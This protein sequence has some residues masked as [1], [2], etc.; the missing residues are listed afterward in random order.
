[1]DW[2]LGDRRGREEK[3]GER[4]C[5]YYFGRGVQADSQVLYDHYAQI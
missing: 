5:V 1:M 3:K 2:K 4:D